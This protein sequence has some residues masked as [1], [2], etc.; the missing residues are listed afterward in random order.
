MTEL[1]EGGSLRNRIDNAEKHIGEKPSVETDDPSEDGGAVVGPG[2]PARKAHAAQV[3]LV[4]PS[5]L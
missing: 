4:H 2:L 3:A 5:F 1:V